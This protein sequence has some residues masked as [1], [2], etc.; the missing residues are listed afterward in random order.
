MNKR[1]TA[2]IS[3]SCQTLCLPKL[4]PAALSSSW[5]WIFY[6]R[7]KERESPKPTRPK[8]LENLWELK[9]D[10]VIQ[11][12][13]KY[14][15]DKVISQAVSEDCDGN[16]TI[17]LSN[18]CDVEEPVKKKKKKKK[19]SLEVENE[20]GR[21]TEKADNQ[22]K[23]SSLPTSAIQ[24]NV[25]KMFQEIVS[26]RET[27]VPLSEV[28]DDMKEELILNTV[29]ESIVENDSLMRTPRECSPGASSEKSS[30]S[31]RSPRKRGNNEPFFPPGNNA[32]P[33]PPTLRVIPS[34][35]L[36]ENPPAE[37]K[38][39]DTNSQED[40]GVPVDDDRQPECSEDGE[41]SNVLLFEVDREVDNNMRLTQTDVIKALKRDDSMRG[42]W[43][44]VKD[45]KRSGNIVSGIIEFPDTDSCLNT[46]KRGLRLNGYQA[47]LSDFHEVEDCHSLG[48]DS[49]H[50]EPSESKNFLD[51]SLSRGM[52]PVRHLVQMEGSLSPEMVP[53]LHTEQMEGSICPE[54]VTV[55]HMEQMEGSLCPEMVPVLH[56]E[57]MEGSICPETVTVLHMEQMEG[58]LC[59]EMVSVLHTEQMEG[60]HSPEMVPVHTVEMEDSLIP[61]ILPVLHV[62]EMEYSLF[63]RILPVLRKTLEDT[64]NPGML[65]EPHA[66]EDNGK[67]TETN[68]EDWVYLL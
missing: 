57:Q 16:S 19:H 49:N 29:T 31:S 38:I 37:T 21:E 68:Y 18:S 61:R 60:F 13:T 28:E 50:P 7:T 67:K 41:T 53:V 10:M 42:C 55:L 27:D 32:R 59:P 36:M 62:V 3:E 1:S 2:G 11:K 12:F 24:E 54:T 14:Y 34:A 30:A 33:A 15:D 40:V 8:C 4:M 66:E 45:M 46:K 20:G 39:A 52:V 63:P 51:N 25:Y 43:I 5:L 6:F 23:W 9:V 47:R 64:P 35:L 22:D 58:S 26:K 56:T 48:D 44:T 65:R 17:S